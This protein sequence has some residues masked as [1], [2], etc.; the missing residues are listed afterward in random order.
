MEIKGK[1]RNI[2]IMCESSGWQW[3]IGAEFINFEL[4]NGI[5]Y[6]VIDLGFLGEFTPKSR[7]RLMFGG[8]RMRKQSLEFFKRNNLK[9]IKHF[10]LRKFQN[11]QTIEHFPL[12]Q[13]PAINSIVE[14]C[15][16]V[17]LEL[18]KVEDKYIKIAEN[19]FYKSNLVYSALKKIDFSN[20]EKVVTVNGRFTKSATVVKFCKE[21][22]IKLG[23]LEGGNNSTS[24]QEF[25]VGPHST[26]ET[27]E[28]IS[29][30]WNTASEPYRSEIS[31]KYLDNIVLRRRIPGIDFRSNIIWD[32]VPRF[33]GKKT[34]A[35]F[36][37]SEWEYYGV[38]ESVQSGYFQNQIEALKALVE[39]LDKD[40]WDIYLRRHPV[41]H[42]SDQGDGEKSLWTHFRNIPNIFIIEPD[43]AIDSIALGLC[44]DLIASY[45]STINVEFYARKLSNVI[46][47]GP[48]PWNHLLPERY[49]PTKEKILDFMSSNTTVIQADKLF[50]WAYYQIE[51]GTEFELI[52]T[53]K[54]SGRWRMKRHNLRSF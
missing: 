7:I 15:Q 41:G 31:R 30:L 53:D 20:V 10:T 11:L 37:S 1:P 2:L 8:F 9:I 43:S 21:N 33:S 22:G 46:T 45:G 3:G 19:E 34:A 17:D 14:R 40:I 25:E 18:I 4:K 27:Q 52:S 50:P 49:L 26:Q 51:S 35:F 5:F 48:A 6:E 38:R 28:K 13:S 47:L 42:K 24:F 54:R 12:E 44:V 16:T 36:A 32:K 23:L 39:I 29:K